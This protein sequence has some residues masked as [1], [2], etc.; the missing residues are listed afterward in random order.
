MTETFLILVAAHLLGD[1]V[2]QTD[3]MAERRKQ[4]KV[5]VLHAALVTVASAVMLGRLHV[6]LLLILLA[7]HLATDALKVHVFPTGI[8]TFLLDQALHLGVI[9]AL[10]CGFPDAAP[11][12][13]WLASL[14]PDGR[15]WYLLIVTFLAG[16]L[17]CVPAGGVMIGVAT[18]PLLEE[19]KAGRRKR[20]DSQLRNRQQHEP[21]G[22]DEGEDRHDADHADNH[23][24]DDVE[25]LGRGG[26]YIGWL[27]R[28]L[29][30]TLLL[31]GQPS[32]IGFLFAAKSILRFGEI[33]DSHQRKVAE[34]IIIGTFLSFGWA[35]L[36]SHLTQQA[37][38]LW[39][40]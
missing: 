16:F 38:K 32:G 26:R 18:A 28:S 29:V 23:A 12:G 39:Q 5:L 13:L 40:K 4:L 3:W 20:R 31:I 8:Q 35:L 36:I 17:L 27:E 19:I 21:G 37:L 33:R 30:M 9:C 2:L 14:S 6:P 10:A 11:G 24:D 22:D 34:Y 25:G 15:R 7:S 1:F